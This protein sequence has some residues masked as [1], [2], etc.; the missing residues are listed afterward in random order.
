MDLA[1]FIPGI[2]N[3]ATFSPGSTTPP[4]FNVSHTGL[5]DG[6]GP[7]TA[8][9]NMAEIYNRLLLNVAATVVK[10]GL[11]IDNNNWTQLATAV[12]TIASNVLAG[13]TGT[14]ITP[15]QFD[16]STAISTTA[17]VQRALGNTNG[18]VGVTTPGFSIDKTQAGKVFLVL[19]GAAVLTINPTG[20]P[21]GSVLH[22]IGHPTQGVTLSMSSGGFRPSA[23][24]PLGSAALLK[25][26]SQYTFV[27][28]G[29]GLLYPINGGGA[30]DFTYYPYTDTGTITLE[31]G[32]TMKWGLDQ[33]SIGETTRSVSFTYAFT[34]ACRN[35]MIV[36]RSVGDA[37]WNNTVPQLVSMS[38]SYFTYFNQGTTG[39]ITNQGIFWFAVGD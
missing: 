13:F 25:A 24:F 20:M 11:T 32:F 29:N 27:C 16:S 7:S 3:T 21:A 5:T 19:D 30:N 34:N 18:V 31:S 14:I 22:F 26:R 38:P 33:T 37:D 39:A 9:K 10:A 28:D 1:S 12:E 17:F 8:S 35:V 15:P 23:L 36:G 2:T 4:P 6:T